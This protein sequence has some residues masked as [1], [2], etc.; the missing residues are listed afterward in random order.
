MFAI[1]DASSM[2]WTALSSKSQ[3]TQPNDGLGEEKVEGPSTD[4]KETDPASFSLQPNTGIKRPRI[5]DDYRLSGVTGTEKA[6][7]R[8]A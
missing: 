2:S 7:K 5:P 1:E 6:L 3:T 8:A 4:G